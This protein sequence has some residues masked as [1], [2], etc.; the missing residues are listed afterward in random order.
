VAS[1]NDVSAEKAA[2]EHGARFQEEDE[3][4]EREKGAAAQAQEGQESSDGVV[5]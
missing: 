1:E 4:E 2:E 3:H 5:R